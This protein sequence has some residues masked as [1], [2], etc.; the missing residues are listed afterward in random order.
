[1]RIIPAIDL[2]DGRCVRLY[3]GDFK[4]TTE[5]A[6]DPQSQLQRF[7]ADG[8]QFI[9]IVDLDGARAGKAAQF[10]LIADLCSQSSVPIQVGGGIRSLETIE[11][12]LD[13]GVHRVILGTAALEDPSFIRQSLAKFR[14]NIVI[15]IDARN[16]KVATRGWETTTEIDYIDFGKQMESLGAQTIVFTDISR[17]GTLTGPNIAQLDKINKAVSCN[18]IASGGITS[19]KDLENISKIGISEAI[20]GKAIYEGKII[21]KGA[22]RCVKK[23]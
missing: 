5:V 12:Y 11:R 10:A 21:I 16:E 2:I 14:E 15:G 20:V 19:M 4:Q 13:A 7:I 3:Q 9:H 6:S 17:D 18:I 1:M 23:E 22:D 8:A